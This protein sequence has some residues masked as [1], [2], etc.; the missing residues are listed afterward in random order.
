MSDKNNEKKI[1]LSNDELNLLIDQLF[2]YFFNEKVKEVDY[3]PSFQPP[4]IMLDEP[5][6]TLGISMMILKQLYS[7]A[8]EETFNNLKILKN[9]KEKNT[10]NTINEE[11]TINNNEEEISKYLTKIYYLSYTV[12]AIKGDL[13]QI[14]NFRK[15]FLVYFLSLPSPSFSIIHPSL[16]SSSSNSSI[17]NI[18]LSILLKEL[19][20]L[21][22][23]FTKHP[24]SPAAWEHRRWCI[25]ERHSLLLERNKE[26]NNNKNIDELHNNKK[27][28]QLSL[29]E[30]ETEKELARIMASKYP[31]NYYAWTHRQWL[32]PYMNSVQL[33]EELLFTEEWLLENVSDHSAV[34]HRMQ[35]IQQGLKDK[36]TVKYLCSIRISDSNDS[37]N[38]VSYST[39]ISDSDINSYSH[40]ELIYFFLYN[41]LDTS[42]DMIIKKPG[43]ESLW[44]QRRHLSEFILQKIHEEN[45]NIN[46][47]IEENIENKLLNNIN[48]IKLLLNN[49]NNNENINENNIINK[50]IIIN[51]HFIL[52]FINELIFFSNIIINKSLWNYNEQIIC[53]IKYIIFFIERVSSFFFILLFLFYI[54]FFYILNYIN[55]IF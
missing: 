28:I 29:M 30:I 44:C 16:A 3:M 32:L 42:G 51:N 26:N 43:Y 33:D 50:K 18:K 35:V 34:N 47:N 27:D 23:V 7:Y 40:D 4:W 6:S 39:F 19:S 20:Y 12:L 13:F 11:D 24:K 2:Q 9:I 14:Y 55:F 17:Y 37:S 8:Y 41:L 48:N 46:K 15:E 38:P 25:Y 53:G 31:K 1:I 10:N 45:K 49:I 36:E 22:A 5:S 21:S 54:Q 52:F